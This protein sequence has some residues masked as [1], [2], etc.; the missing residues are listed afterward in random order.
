MGVETNIK[1]GI[2]LNVKDA[3]NVAQLNGVIRLSQISSD[4]YGG[5]DKCGLCAEAA[6]DIDGRVERGWF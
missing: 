3:K 2:N 4:I 1:F 5:C 6:N